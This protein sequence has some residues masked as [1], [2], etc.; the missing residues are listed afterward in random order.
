MGL[1]AIPEFGSVRVP[2]PTGVVAKTT[3]CSESATPS[4][5]A[6]YNPEMGPNP[7]GDHPQ[8]INPF[9]DHPQGT[10]PFGDHPMGTAPYVRTIP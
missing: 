1:A 2:V 6:G 10:N 4:K 5:A 3:S 7:F 9:G 8:G